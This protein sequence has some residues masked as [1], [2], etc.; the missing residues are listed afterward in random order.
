MNQFRGAQMATSAMSR[1]RQ[2][3]LVFVFFTVVLAPLLS[4]AIVGGLGFSI[5]IYQML[6]GPP[7]G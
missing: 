6:N 1:R 3:L 4:V 7:T 2:E 5:W